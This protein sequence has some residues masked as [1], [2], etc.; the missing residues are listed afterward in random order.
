MRDLSSSALVMSSMV[1]GG[2]RIAA[3]ASLGLLEAI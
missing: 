2:L 3:A 1:V